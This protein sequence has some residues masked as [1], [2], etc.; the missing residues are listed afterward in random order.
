MLTVVAIIAGLLV[1]GLLVFI[2]LSHSVRVTHVCE[3][4]APAGGEAPR[5]GDPAF[6]EAIELLSTTPLAPGHGVEILR[7]GD[8]TFPRLWADLR[9]AQQSITLQ[10][11]DCAPGAL[12][13]ALHEILSERARAGVRV[14]FLYDAFG[15]SFTDEWFA[16]L[17]AASVTARPFRPMSVL[18]IHKLQHRAHIRVVCVDGTVGWT[19][20]FGIADKWLGNGRTPGEWRDSNVRF[21]GPA[22]RQLQAVFVACWAET[23]GKLLVGEPL[24]IPPAEPIAETAERHG[25]HGGVLAGLLH[26]SP[27]IGSTEAERYFA[28]TIAAARDRLWITNA[29]FVPDRDFRNL[30]AAAVNRGVDV[31]V[32]TAGPDCDVQSTLY[33]GRARFEEMLAAGIRIY[34]YRDTMMHAKTLVVDGQWAACGSMN[35]DNRSLSFNEETLLLMLDRDIAATL[36][37]HF[38]EDIEQADEV[39][40][41][42][43]RQRGAWMRIKERAAHLVWRVL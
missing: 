5:V 22:V 26:G 9:A 10:L 8:E 33:A 11:Y 15:T 12:A 39:D 1:F 21:T 34:E 41:A 42:V 2:A 7:N 6:R 4:E 19:G 17:E 28:L 38:L 16:T 32:I 25:D 24:F 30:L 14:I 13:D 40:L 20:G 29:Y 35:A 27:S 36:E 43:F 37:R 18:A 3:V 23:T 31:R